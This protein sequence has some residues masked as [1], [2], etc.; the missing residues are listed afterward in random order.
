MKLDLITIEAFKPVLSSKSLKCLVKVR[1]YFIDL[2]M[3]LVAN[4]NVVLNVK[5]E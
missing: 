4:I 3:N 2:I 1:L 5:P